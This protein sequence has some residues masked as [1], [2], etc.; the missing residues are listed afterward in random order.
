[1]AAPL[2]TTD[3]LVLAFDGN[4]EE[5]RRIAGDD[6]TGTARADRVAYGIGVASEEGYG[7]LRAGFVTNEAIQ[8][9]AANDP[10]V[11]HALAMIFREVLAQGKSEFRLPDGQTVFS[12]DARR[13]RDLLREKSRG[14]VRT[15]AEEVTPNGP[16]E[17]SLL[18]PRTA[19][20]QRSVLT[21]PR[22]GKVT[23]F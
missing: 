8:R 23:G 4:A 1:M 9:L 2:I 14:G 10:A 13:A 19:N 5:L 15:S 21:D 3:D 11:R 22:T 7:I 18:R 12:G 17:S 16:G 20:T 6:G